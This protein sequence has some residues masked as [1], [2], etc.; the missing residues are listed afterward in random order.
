MLT[1]EL[2]PVGIELGAVNL[3]AGMDLSLRGKIKQGSQTFNGRCNK[4]TIR[5]IVAVAKVSTL[6]TI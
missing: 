6:A 3:V 5:I 4:S 1:L 2:G